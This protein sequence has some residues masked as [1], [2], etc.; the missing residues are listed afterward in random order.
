MLRFSWKNLRVYVHEQTR[1]VIFLIRALG[2]DHFYGEGGDHQFFSAPPLVRSKMFWPPSNDLKKILPPPLPSQEKILAP[3]LDTMKNFGSPWTTP[4][5]V[6]P[7]TQVES[8]PTRNKWYLPE[9]CN[10]L[11]ADIRYNCQSLYENSILYF[12]P[13]LKGF[14][15][16][17]Q[18]S[19]KCQW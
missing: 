10:C 7:T 13:N 17:Y 11:K 6:A 19:T 3:L 12:R 4:K 14:E 9:E 2:N 8:P 16:F 1:S 15:I 18:N 5:N